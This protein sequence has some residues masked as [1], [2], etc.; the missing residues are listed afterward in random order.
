MVLK[1]AQGRILPGAVEAIERPQVSQGGSQRST[2]RNRR[3]WRT[4]TGGRG[5]SVPSMSD[6]IASRPLGVISPPRPARCGA[7]ARRKA[8]RSSSMPVP[9]PCN[10]L[11]AVAIKLVM[12]MSHSTN[13]PSRGT[14]FSLPLSAEEGGQHARLS[15]VAD[16]FGAAPL[17][18]GA[19]PARVGGCSGMGVL[20]RPWYMCGVIELGRGGCRRCDSGLDGAR[21]KRAPGRSASGRSGARAAGAV[22]GVCRACVRRRASTARA[23]ARHSPSTVVSLRAR[24]RPGPGRSRLRFQAIAIPRLR[25][26]RGRRG[27]GDGVRAA[28]AHRRHRT[29]SVGGRRSAG[30][31]SRGWGSAPSAAADP[32][33]RRGPSSWRPTRKRVVRTR[34]GSVPP[35]DDGG[36]LARPRAPIVEPIAEVGRARRPF[37]GALFRAAGR[38]RRRIALRSRASRH[39]GEARPGRRPRSSRTDRAIAILGASS[40]PAS[41]PAYGGCTGP[42]AAAMKPPP[43]SRREGAPVKPA[44]I[45]FSPRALAAEP[46]LAADYPAPVQGDYLS[47]R[48]ASRRAADVPQSPDAGPA[49]QGTRPAASSMPRSCRMARWVGVQFMGPSSRANSSAPASCSMRPRTTSSSSTTSATANAAKAT[50]CGP[51]SRR[52]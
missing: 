48:R 2:R 43:L 27:V 24:H 34:C 11:P 1:P 3:K 28:P 6:T 41:W 21:S 44:A 9:C 12:G 42:H 31:T 29:P 14:R 8:R 45:P 13:N 49:P 39:H 51:S 37:G 19:A 35:P 38:P 10:G 30:R 4:I 46:A 50:A 18:A 47:E 20:S 23:S 16:A 7:M 5:A 36:A 15:G 26:R 25:D 22:V 17:A 32:G 33:P 52:K 40:G